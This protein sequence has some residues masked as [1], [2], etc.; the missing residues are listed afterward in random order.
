[1]L[2]GTPLTNETIFYPKPQAN[3]ISLQSLLQENEMTLEDVLGAGAILKMNFEY[4]CELKYS[5]C[6]PE[7]TFDRLSLPEDGVI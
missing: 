3:A 5:S 4:N 7:I 6:E 2:Y 1:M